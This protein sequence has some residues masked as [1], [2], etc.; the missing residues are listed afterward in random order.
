VSAALDTLSDEEQKLL[1]QMETDDGEPAPFLPDVPSPGE[2]PQAAEE[3]AP[4]AETPPSATVPQQALHEERA[5]R[6]EVERK[7]QEAE[8]R[9]AANE[10]RTQERLNLLMQA[11][12]GQAP[13]AAPAPAAPAAPPPDISQDPIGYVQHIERDMRQTIS[14]L[15]EK[16]Q[17][18]EGFERQV[19][20]EALHR[21]QMQELSSWGL[22][23]ETEFAAEQPD[24]ANAAQFVR[25]TRV[26]QL[27]ALGITNPQQ[28]MAQIAQDVTQIA[29]SARNSGRNFGRTLYDLAKATGYTPA[30]QAA[31]N[32]AAPA[33]SPQPVA[34]AGDA[35]ARA[36]RGAEMATTIGSGGSAPRGELTPQRLAEMP[37]EEFTAMLGKLGKSGMRQMFGE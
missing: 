5:R 24:Y 35:T 26:R 20:E 28:V 15:Q 33:L 1:K 23:Q 29:L 36:Q 3:P 8:Q 17:K 22:Q 27:Q 34:N 19:N 30:Q 32:A 11:V 21:A 37:E 13:A 7:L 2:A 12:Q 10:A 4:A 14:Q 31:A 16:V 25:E 9:H 18:S 6:K